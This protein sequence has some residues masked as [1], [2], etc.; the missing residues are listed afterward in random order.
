[1]FGWRKR[2]EGFEWKEYVRTT[3]LVR[4]ADRQR[5]LDDARLSALAQVKGVKDRGVEASKRKIDNAKSRARSVALNLGRAAWQ[6]GTACWQAFSQLAIQGWSTARRLVAEVPVPAIDLPPWIKSG[7]AEA[8]ARLPALPRDLVNKRNALA[9]G[10]I[11]LAFAGGGLVFS[12]PGTFS[13]PGVQV[14][15]FTPSAAK[16]EQITGDISGRA[17]AV[18]GEILRISGTL[19]RLTGI[20]AP[21]GSQPCFKTNGRRWSCG[22]AAQDALNRL[23]RSKTVACKLS[24]TDDG[25]R[26]LG[27]CRAGELD[28]AAELVRSGHVFAAPGFFQSYSSEEAAA[29]TAKAGLWQGDAERPN[30]WRQRLWEEA[31]KAAPDGCPIKG[32]IRTGGRIYT[33]PWS[34]DYANARLR[35]VKGE[36]W[37]CTED[38]ARAAGFKLSTRS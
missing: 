24:G 14:S 38:E 22:S 23:V 13:V 32:I 30:A 35:T 11:G 27:N 26:A 1:M 34:T 36:R 37:F 18:S 19:V 3:V 7:V 9:A 10:A 28:V 15:K 33:M 5:R 16:T 4:R 6:A 25:G 8:A 12:K 17:N 29:Q 20:E 31:K 21:E 2:S